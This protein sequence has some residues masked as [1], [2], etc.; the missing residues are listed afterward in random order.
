MDGRSRKLQKGGSGTKG[1]RTAEQRA[2]NGPRQKHRGREDRGGREGYLLAI[3]RHPCVRRSVRERVGSRWETSA[4]RLAYSSFSS[5]RDTLPD[6][7][8]KYGQRMRSVTVPTTTKRNFLSLFL[9]K[10][11][12]CEKLCIL[13]IFEKRVILEGHASVKNDRYFIEQ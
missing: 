9:F 13:T 3:R 11:C 10:I 12:L 5:V 6:V 2:D 1:A 8:L 4:H 7:T